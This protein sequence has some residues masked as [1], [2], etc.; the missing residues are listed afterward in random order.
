MTAFLQTAYKGHP[1]GWAWWTTKKLG[2]T[3]Q[4]WTCPFPPEYTALQANWV[5]TPQDVA[6]AAL[7]K[8][9]Q[10]LQTSNCTYQ[11]SYVQ[12]LGGTP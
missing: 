6:F 9:A 3:H 4:P 10:A 7:S 11:P 12:A 5:G 1:I 2:G 8:W